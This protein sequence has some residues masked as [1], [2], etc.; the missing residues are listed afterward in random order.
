MR[1]FNSRKTFSNLLVVMG[2][3]FFYFFLNNYQTCMGVVYSLL[4]TI[5][6]FLWAFVWAYLLNPVVNFFESKADGLPYKRVVAMV[7]TYLFLFVL[8]SALFSIVLPEVTS[9]LILLWEGLPG[10]VENISAQADYWTQRFGLHLD[11]AQMVNDMWNRLNLNITDTIQK[12]LPQV[13]DVSMNVG[14]GVVNALMSLVASVYMLAGKDRLKRQTKKAVYALIPRRQAERILDIGRRCNATFSGFINGKILDSA[15]IGLLCFG[16]MAMLR[17]DYAVLISIIVGITNIVPF[18]G[19]FIGAVPS[20]IL[21]LIVDPLQALVFLCLIIGLQQFD[22]NILGPAILGDSLGISSLWTLFAIVVGGSLFGIGGI[23]MGVPLFAVAY[24]LV[25]EYLEQRLR[26]RHLTPTGET[27][28]GY[29]E[30][31]DDL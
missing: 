20:T 18:F 21:L 28:E 2:G 24:R 8:C 15:I 5:S 17:L 31:D 6:P 27:V 4:D 25:S 10:Y 19:P 16:L 1:K 7:V 23:L 22:G 9:S 3:V 30:D 14:S 11:G 26:E 29:E 13:I 12:V